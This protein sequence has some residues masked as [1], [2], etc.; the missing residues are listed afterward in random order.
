MLE[1]YHLTF[2]MN[3]FPDSAHYH[4]G[5][6]MCL[7]F[8]SQE[9]PLTVMARIRLSARPFAHH[10]ADYGYPTVPLAAIESYLLFYRY[11]NRNSM[12]RVGLSGFS[13]STLQTISPII[14]EAF[15][16]LIVEA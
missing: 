14:I 8:A 7:H 4:S 15:P 2:V 10:P 1:Q 16:D 6:G 11:G 9:R 5:E 12:L 3:L 13:M